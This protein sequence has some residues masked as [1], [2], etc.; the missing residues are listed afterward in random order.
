[1]NNEF[2]L[3]NGTKIPMIGYG[4][5]I[6][7]YT[8]GRQKHYKSRV[9][10]KLYWIYQKKVVERTKYSGYVDSIANAIRVGYRLIDYSSAYEHEDLLGKAIAKSGIPREELILTARISDNAQRKGLVREQVLNAIKKMGVSYVDILQFH[11]PLSK[12][13]ID[14]WKEMQ[15]LRNEGCC[16]IL[17]VANCNIHHIE[18]IY[19][20]TGEYPLINQF[21]C[22]PMFTQEELRAYCRDK[23][24]QVEAYTPVARY[25]DRLV[26]MPL[27]RRLEAKYNKNFVQIILR[28]HVQ[29]GVIPVFRS[30]NPEHQ[31]KNSE[32]FDFQLSDEDMKKIDD[33]NINSRLR[34]DPD[35]FEYYNE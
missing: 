20:E 19:N 35:K 32:I 6:L 14:T 31:K 18:H 22:H 25:D 17:G 21:E 15:S 8:D 16:K 33:M 30:H 3:S 12:Y 29:N 26:N 28:W 27:M 11:W 34:Y 1:M 23:G 5:G 13:Y 10:Q 2:T 4:P 24:I 9:L 7:G